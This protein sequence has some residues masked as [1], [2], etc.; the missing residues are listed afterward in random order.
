[1]RGGDA[2]RQCVL[3]VVRDRLVARRLL[4]PPGFGDQRAV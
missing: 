1:M 2:E 3:V 4:A